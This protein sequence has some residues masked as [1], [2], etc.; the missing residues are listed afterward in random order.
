VPAQEPFER[1]LSLFIP[2]TIGGG[3]IGFKTCRYHRMGFDRLLV[4][5]RARS[6]APIK[7]VAANRPKVT[8]LGGLHLS[9]PAEAL[10]TALKDL[11][12]PGGISAKNECLRQ[13]R[14]IIGQDF[15]KPG[16][17]GLG[18]FLE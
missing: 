12:L 16:P 14:I 2:P 1:M 18:N 13:L 5:I 4:E 17:I 11:G 7:P 6:T 9:Q 3:A 10:K 15:L 8:G